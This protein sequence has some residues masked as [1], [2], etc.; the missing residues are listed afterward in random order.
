ML[1]SGIAILAG[2]IILVWSAERFISGAAAC[3][4]HF[5]MSPLLIGMLIVG[6]GT[7][8][9]EMVV[10]G[11]AALDGQPDLGLGNALGS[12]LVN[13]GL[14]LGITALVTPILVHSKIVRKEIPLL[15]GI[16]LA[17][18]AFLY[19]GAL[20]RLE[21]TVLVIGFFALVAWT[22]FAGRDEQSDHL[23]V[24][25]QETLDQQPLS[26][27]V[28]VMWLAVGLL[29]LIASSELLVWG[30]V[31]IAEQLGVSSLIIGLTIVALGTS[32]PE[33][34]AS[35]VAARSGQYDIAIGNV[36]GSNMFNILAVAG[37][38]GT[39]APIDAL[40]PA[41]LTRDWTTVMALTIALWVMA[42]GF[43]KQGV[44][45][46][47]DGA[48]LLIAFIAYNTYLISGL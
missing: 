18:G 40:N 14:V 35:I 31:R 2:F 43:G 44:I 30:A 21:S 4:E 16:G 1:L 19:D 38:A 48:I 29:L 13:T 7:S 12:N 15:L 20:S 17:F 46:R 36:V 23:G 5:G 33:L 37:I 42:F 11:Q 25:V 26:L 9:P 47:L 34:A 41:I 32:L 28:A 27:K 10:S 22:F 45:S 6:F 39:I 3:A 8:A 24:E